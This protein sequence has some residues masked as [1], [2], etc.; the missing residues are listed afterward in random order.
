MVRAM[1]K[2]AIVLQRPIGRGPLP[3]TVKEI[4]AEALEASRC[5]FREAK[6]ALQRDDSETN[7][8]RYSR[9]LFKYDRLQGMFPFVAAGFTGDAEA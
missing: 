5:E 3:R 6:D 8:A 2:P 1:R 9:A 4:Y 7:Q